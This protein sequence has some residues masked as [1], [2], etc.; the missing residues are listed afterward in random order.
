[1]KYAAISALVFLLTGC[2]GMN[3]SEQRMVSGAA[4]GALVGGPIGGGVGAT[5]GAGVG[6]GVGY[7]VDRSRDSY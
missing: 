1:M 4:I 3:S 5:I 6:A 7:A 2:A